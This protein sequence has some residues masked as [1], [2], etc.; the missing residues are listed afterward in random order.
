[1]S[2]ENQPA[3]TGP[4]PHA[5][6]VSLNLLAR[7]P[8]RVFFPVA[9]LVGLA[10]AAVWP[11]H[12]LGIVPLYPGLSHAR[13]MAYGFFGGFMV[14]FLGTALPRMLSAPPLRVLE[15]GVLLLIYVVMAVALLVGKIAVGD[16]L[17]V[18]LLVVF[19]LFLGVRIWKRGD[20]PP[21]SFVLVALALMCAGAGALLSILIQV[22]EEAF[23]YASLQH[24]LSYQAFILLPILG[25]G[26]YLLP[27]FFGMATRQDFPESR[28]PPPGWLSKFAVA[29]MVGLLIVASFFMEAA[30]WVR[31]G[32]V[33]R[34]L[35]TGFYLVWEVP[36]YRVK[37]YRG[38][39]AR[40]LQVAFTLL[41]VGFLCVSVDPERRVS[42]LHLTL[43][44]GFA[45]ITLVVAT[46][47][48]Y[49]HSG[50]AGLLARRNRWLWVSVGIILLAMATRISGDFWPQVMASH[51]SYGALGWMAGL[52]LWA[53]YVIPKVLRPDED[54]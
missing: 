1:M 54:A 49:G 11:L 10:G 12:F 19:A 7:E 28:W 45:V 35:A 33:L 31:V 38:P 24:L 41:L 40:I 47:V 21:P 4:A 36:F 20:V 44:G 14:G 3:S 17:F 37:E 22:N 32:P 43:V 50:N 16:A 8:F 52:L 42:L 27:R 46:R 53:V 51:Y 29:L 18:G 30:G 48:V 23:G 15:T 26:A 2:T 13:L 6:Q 39:A 5:A 25:V 34:L 9:V